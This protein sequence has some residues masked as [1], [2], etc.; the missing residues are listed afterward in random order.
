MKFVS[1]VWFGRDLF[2]G[3]GLDGNEDGAGSDCKNATR[4]AGAVQEGR[5]GV[6]G[7]ADRQTGG[8]VKAPGAQIEWREEVSTA[9]SSQLVPLGVQSSVDAKSDLSMAES[10]NEQLVQTMFVV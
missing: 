4:M 10:Y 7:R 2:P 3:C 5:W 1:R 8:G 6:F 9:S